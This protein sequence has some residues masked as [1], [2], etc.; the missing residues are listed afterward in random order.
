MLKGQPTGEGDDGNTDVAQLDPPARSSQ[1]HRWMM[2]TP[3]ARHLDGL[4]KQVNR[5]SFMDQLLSG[6]GGYV[7]LVTTVGQEQVPQGR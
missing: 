6:G 5:H 4:K 7:S 1:L 3:T 2:A